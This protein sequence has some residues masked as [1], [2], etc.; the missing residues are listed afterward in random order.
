LQMLNIINNHFN[1]EQYPTNDHISNL[2]ERDTERLR[3]IN[4]EIKKSQVRLEEIKGLDINQ[5]I[6]DRMI[7]I[8]TG[9]LQKVHPRSFL[10]NFLGWTFFYK[11]G[12]E[13]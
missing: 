12:I 10:T 1:I 7:K 11:G 5:S 2:L 8:N 3:A 4:I 13:V 9:P 6:K